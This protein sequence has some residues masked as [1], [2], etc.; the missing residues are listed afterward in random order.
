MRGERGEVTGQG[1]R[2][3]RDVDDDPRSTGGDPRTTAL[4]A[5]ARGG[6]STTTS[7]CPVRLTAS[8]DAV[9]PVEDGP[10]L[11]LV[12]QVVTRVRRPPGGATRPRRTAPS[13]PDPVRE[14][15]AE[16][17][18][19]GVQVQQRSPG[20]GSST[21]QDRGS[22]KV[23]AA[24]GCTCQKPP[25][26]RPASAAPPRPPSRSISVPGAARRRARR[27]STA[28][29]RPTRSR[30]RARPQRTAGHDVRSGSGRP[31]RRRRSGA[32]ATPAALRRAGAPD[33]GPPAQTV[34]VARRPPRRPRRRSTPASRCSCS[35]TTAP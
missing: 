18:D 21:V 30:W 31:G 6:S 14:H 24:P 15:P 17:P 26:D 9:D 32:P 20:C 4:P 5:P 34:L 7:R 27:C 1:G 28:P 3:A 25:C 10:D 16:Q 8:Q 35:R 33:P 23:S 2:V 11:R 19:A 13:G 29:T 12:V 22:T